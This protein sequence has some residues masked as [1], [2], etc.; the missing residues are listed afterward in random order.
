MT[1]MSAKVKAVVKREGHA[2]PESNSVITL[3]PSPLVTRSF[4][5]E[6]A[7]DFAYAQNWRM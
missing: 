7:T 2:M 6:T 1:L 3:S 5:G 4:G